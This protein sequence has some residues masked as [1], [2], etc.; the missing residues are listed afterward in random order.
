MISAVTVIGDILRPR[1]DGQPG[2]VDRMTRWLADA[3]APAIRLATGLAVETVTTDG[4]DGLGPWICSLRPPQRADAYW[5]AQHDELPATPALEWLVLSRL[6]GRFCV[7]WELPPWLRRLLDD[8]GVPYLDI[9]L[10]PVRFLDDLIFAVR[11]ADPDIQA[12]L[13]RLAVPEAEVIVTAG[14]RVAMGRYISQAAV[15]DGTL[16]VAGQRR[17]DSTQIHAGAFW[18]AAPH[19]AAIHALCAEHPATVLKPHPLDPGHSLLTVAAGA[20]ARVLGVI[21]DNVYRMM[22]LPQVAAI[23]TVNSG[24]AV[25]AGYFGKR[26]HTLLP[27][28]VRLGWAA[29]APDSA[30]HVS[31]GDAVL[32]PD[33][34]RT[35]LAPCT[36]VSA[37]DGFRLAPKPNRLRIALDSFWNF[38]EIDTDRIPQPPP[39]PMPPSPTPHAVAPSVG[40]ATIRVQ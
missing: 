10:H 9:R 30:A 20:P 15:P 7:G 22:A 11:A 23:L 12:A 16:L 14:L 31:I 39:P 13:Y 28:P 36:D 27:S 33:F 29:Q 35:V 40:C 24:V 38:Q 1:G 18:D 32:V 19:T 17:F 4:T 3:I 8:R 21:R 37:A 26:V 34:W 25:E 6:T 2:E 5:A